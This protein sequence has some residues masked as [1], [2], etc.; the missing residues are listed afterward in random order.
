M[1]GQG[2]V[3]HVSNLAQTCRG[4]TS[5][6]AGDSCR[7][8]PTCRACNHAAMLGCSS[9]C[10]SVSRPFTDA[11]K[12]AIA[13]GFVL[14]AVASLGCKRKGLREEK[15]PNGTVRSRG[16]VAQDAQKHDVLVGLWTT[17]YE[18]GQKQEE[19]HYADG[20]R[21]GPWTFWR[22]NGLKAGEGP[23]ASGDQEG[24]WRY[25]HPNGQPSLSG[26]FAN[27][28]R[29]GAWTFWHSNGQKQEEGHYTNGMRMGDWTFW[30]SNG[31]QAEESHY[32]NGR[33]TGA[34]T[35]W[36]ASGQKAFEGHYENGEKVGAWTHWRED[37]VKEWPRE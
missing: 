4:G 16:E 19:G 29:V 28:K 35:F 17:W 7:L 9:F 32:A 27:G 3:G 21:V 1:F 31:Q 23:Y 10:A 2:D 5:I 34:S 8:P 15:Y 20:K 26:H 6:V 24:D 18:N 22:A 12:R 37:G 30:H 25:W 14:L 13:V 11:R 33:R 36:Y